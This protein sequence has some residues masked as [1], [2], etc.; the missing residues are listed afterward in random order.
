MSNPD[1]KQAAA[2]GS[3]AI[4]SGRDTVIQQG[5][6]PADLQKILAGLGEQ[7][8][9]YVS[10]ARTEVDRRLGEFEGR[11]L[12]RFAKD[13]ETNANAFRDPD[14]QY[15]VGRAQHAYAR[16]GDPAVGDILVDIIARRSQQTDRNRLALTLNNAVEVAATLT[17]NEFA[18]LSLCF[19]L[20]Y[21]VNNDVRDIQSFASYFAR[22]IA[23]LL[24]D[25]SRENASY[26]Y[27]E[28]RGCG[29][30]QIM[31]SSLPQILRTTYAGVFSNGFERSVVEERV[32]RQLVST[33]EAMKGLIPCM[34]DKGKLQVGVLNEDQWKLVWKNLGLEENDAIALWNL[35]AGSIWPE[36][37]FILRLPSYVPDYATLADIWSST[38]LNSFTLTTLGIAIGH[39][40]ICRIT[41]FGA[42]LGL[43]IK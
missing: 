13:A 24:P 25:I 39:A 7:I 6:T 20:R 30:T 31:N 4:Q 40:N 26:Q 33:L 12:E 23:P 42:G 16:S 5:L 14:F 21:T 17:S 10:L 3:T 2:D 38:P 11:V 37:D 9:V 15:T 1:Q 28:S 34:N 29:S 8:S 43:W 18:E 22:T 27:M 36:S 35:M 19:V 41:K 32:S